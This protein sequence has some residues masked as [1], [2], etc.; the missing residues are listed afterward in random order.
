MRGSVGY[1]P[2]LHETVYPL[3][4]ELL[5]AIALEIRGPVACRGIQWFL[6]LALAVNVMVLARPIVGK[7]AWWAAAVVLLVPAVSNGMTGAA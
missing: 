1:L 2:D 4:T 3:I 7:R 5:Y 6:G